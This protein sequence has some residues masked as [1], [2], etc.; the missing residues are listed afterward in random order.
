MKARHLYE[1]VKSVT[2][3]YF[4]ILLTALLKTDDWV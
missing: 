4:C 1:T 3:K 2:V